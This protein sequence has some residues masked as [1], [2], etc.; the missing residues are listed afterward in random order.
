MNQ[1]RRM[2]A[3]VL[4][5]ALAGAFGGLLAG[6]S[7]ERCYPLQL[8]GGETVEMGCAG[9]LCC[10][11]GAGLAGVFVFGWLFG[12]EVKHFFEGSKWLR[13][14]GLS[15]VFGF[16]GISL[17]ETLS[18]ST[19]RRLKDALGDEM[20]AT[21]YV[22]EGKERLKEAFQLIEE[23]QH[24]AAEPN[25][26]ERLERAR[27][28]LDRSKLSLD[29]ALSLRP[30]NEEAAIQKAKVVAAE[31]RIVQDPRRKTEKLQEAEVLLSGVITKNPKNAR[32]LYNRACYRSLARQPQAALEDLDKAIQ[33]QKTYA[34][35]AK[36]DGDFQN[37]RTQQE[38]KFLAVVERR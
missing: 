10:G 35:H 34:D 26:E 8:P 28:M 11:M 38:R 14:L 22:N 27:V 12:V 5:I 23:L 21:N 29:R 36:A 18:S 15:I 32:A 16:M 31:G 17:L 20:A 1:S 7:T 13:M 2:A 19:M 37:L 3:I 25:R 33:L 30:D 9:D 24:E 6:M 4:A